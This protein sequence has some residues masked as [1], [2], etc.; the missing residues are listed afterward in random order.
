MTLGLLWGSTL[1]ALG[2]WI[3]ASLSATAPLL[4]LFVVVGLWVAL[5]VHR[6][7]IHTSAAIGDGMLTLSGSSGRH[8]TL[9]AASI[10]RSATCTVEFGGGR[11]S[12]SR[13]YQLI[14]TDTEWVWAFDLREWGQE[15]LARLVAGLGRSIHKSP[16]RNTVDFARLG[17][18]Y[19]G[20]AEWWR[21]PASLQLVVVVVF[22]ALAAF[23]GLL[24]VFGAAAFAR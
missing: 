15:D 14:G 9:P 5:L 10:T 1:L 21:A 2:F 11:A 6:W 17:I 3:H 20:V 4:A 23:I 12:I 8:L 24:L 19:P 22:A 16:D 7:R 13:T 18:K